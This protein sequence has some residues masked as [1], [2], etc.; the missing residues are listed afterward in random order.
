MFAPAF[1]VECVNAGYFAAFIKESRILMDYYDR[2]RVIKRTLPSG[3]GLGRRRILPDYRAWIRRQGIVNDDCRAFG[4][5]G[6]ELEVRF[7]RGIFTV[8]EQ[9]TVGVASNDGDDIVQFV[10]DRRGDVLCRIKSLVGF[11]Q[12]IRARRR[13]RHFFVDIFQ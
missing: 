8:L 1:G 5:F 10:R 6:D 12:G 2:L 11:V 7:E 4:R 3:R 13:L 9:Q